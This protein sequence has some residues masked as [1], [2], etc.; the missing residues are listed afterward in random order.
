MRAVLESE[1][2][3]EGARVLDTE[4]KTVREAAAQ[5]RAIMTVLAS[6][7]GPAIGQ[8]VALIREVEQMEEIWE[9]MNAVLFDKQRFDEVMQRQYFLETKILFKEYERSLVSQTAEQFRFVTPPSTPGGSLM[10]SRAGSVRS[11]NSFSSRPC[12]V[13]SD[14]TG[15]EFE[16]AAGGNRSRN[17]SVSSYQSANQSNPHNKRSSTLSTKSQDSGF[18]SQ[19]ILLLR[20]QEALK[21]VSRFRSENFMRL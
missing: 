17:N 9:K 4:R 18:S 21:Q 13:A 20:Q 16:A 11:L 6:G 3:Q 10:G 5:E 19:D 2:R 12:S 15:T 8:E 14:G 7:L 1:L